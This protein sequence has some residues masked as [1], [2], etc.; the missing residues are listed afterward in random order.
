MR[1]GWAI[2]NEEIIEKMTVM[3]SN[4]SIVNSRPSEYIA[5]KMLDKAN[6][7]LEDY[8]KWLQPRRDIIVSW[9]K[10][11]HNLIEAISPDGGTVIFPRLIGIDNDIKFSEELYKEYSTL[12]VPGSL[13]GEKGHIR[14]GY[15]TDIDILNKGLTNIIDLLLRKTNLD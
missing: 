15:A 6:E 4:L 5:L 12:V 11:N 9:I 2:A 8:Q 7:I 3:R 10:K 13:F 1:I 14:I